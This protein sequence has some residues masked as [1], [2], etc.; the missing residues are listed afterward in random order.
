VEDFSLFEHALKLAGSNIENLGDV[1]HLSRQN[2]IERETFLFRASEPCLEYASL[3]IENSLLLRARRGGR[4]YAGFEQLSLMEAVVDRYMRIAD[5]SER[6]YVFGEDD[7]EPPR[8]PNMR[9]VLL[10]RDARLAREWFIVAD[11]PAL[12]TALIGVA[13]AAAHVCAPEERTFRT[14]KTDN[15]A[16]VEQLALAVENFI[17]AS[18][19]PTSKAS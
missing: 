15:P 18:S 8:H 17:D 9:S 1:P 3:L 13:E 14:F 12:R 16:L 7:W 4:V 2:F 6:L 11:S 5:V 10:P 19:F